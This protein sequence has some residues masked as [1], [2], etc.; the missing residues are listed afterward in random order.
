MGPNRKILN[1]V[2]GEGGRDEIKGEFESGGGLAV[3]GEVISVA[4]IG[5]DGEVGDIA[6]NETFPRSEKFVLV[7]CFFTD[8]EGEELHKGI[9]GEG[10]VGKVFDGDLILRVGIEAWGAFLQ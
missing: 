6:N 7:G 4:G 2:I 10:D 5:V 3:G 8:G 9:F 1:W